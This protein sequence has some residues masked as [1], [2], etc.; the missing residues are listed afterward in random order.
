MKSGLYRR[1]IHHAI[2]VLLSLFIFVLGG[3][4]AFTSHYDA[5]SYE[6]FTALKAFH[7]KFIDDF[8]F[9]ENKQWDDEKFKRKRDEGELRFREALEYEKEKKKEDPLR[10]KAFNILY[11]EFKANCDF[12]EKRAGEGKAFF[13]PAFADELKDVLE[14][15]YG[16]AIEGEVSRMGAPR[17]E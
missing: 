10:E 2:V 17:S 13:S 4:A 6:H 1:R 11:E 3:C 15:N 7:L 5:V 9:E 8:T 12:L 16:Y 14:T